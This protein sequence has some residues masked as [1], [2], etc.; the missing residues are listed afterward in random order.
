MDSTRTL[1]HQTVGR[2]PRR[3]NGHASLIEELLASDR[4]EEPNLDR[5]LRD[6]DLIADDARSKGILG[7]KGIC[8]GLRTYV[9]ELREDRLELSLEDL[10][11]FLIASKRMSLL[12][13]E[14]DHEREDHSDG[15]G[16]CKPSN[17]D[18]ARLEFVPEFLPS[19]IIVEP[20]SEELR[21]QLPPATSSLEAAKVVADLQELWERTP[22]SIA[23]RLDLSAIDRVPIVILV[24]LIRLRGREGDESRLVQLYNGLG[25]IRSEELNRSLARHFQLS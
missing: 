11:V 6:L 3:L 7:I 19:G 15:D 14:R 2:Q 10:D 12:L 4:G 20:H 5:V 13:H 22:T 9:E 8:V 18:L 23:W 24:T 21:I 17:I 25:A 1:K 16:T